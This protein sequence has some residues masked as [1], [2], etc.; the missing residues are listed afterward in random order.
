MIRWLILWCALVFSGATLATSEVS[1]EEAFPEKPPTA[2][3]KELM[4]QRALHALV[5]SELKVLKL[6]VSAYEANIARHQQEW[7]KSY[8]R[9]LREANLPPLVA[10]SGE[11]LQD[12]SLFHHL[13]VVK[14]APKRPSDETWILTLQGEADPL[15]LNQHFQRFSKTGPLGRKIFLSVSVV[16][17]N[18]SWED[19]NLTAPH[20]FTRPLER[21]WQ[22]WFADGKLPVSVDEIALCT[23]APCAE[24]LRA[25]RE[26]DEKSMPTFV[27]AELL[28]ADLLTVEI[29]LQRQVADGRLS[30]TKIDF[31][32]GFV[33]TEMN[34]K[35][36]L[37][38]SDL[39]PEQFTLKGSINKDF[40]STLATLCY[41]APLGKFMTLKNLAPQSDM[42]RQSM[43]VRL[44]N[45][46]HMGQPLRLLEWMKAR[47]RNI[48]LEGKL[49]SFNRKEA[50]ILIHF[51]GGGNN[52][53]SLVSNVKEL[54]SEWGKPLT[55]TDHAEGL[56]FGLPGALT[57]P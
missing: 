16:P 40:N 37:F 47:G 6:D 21:E 5:V 4:H 49:D 52:F 7:Q 51:V 14:F 26:H 12:E 54:E 17:V 57:S 55:V 15:L 18:F 36:R 3:D 42:P 22:K 27:S 50:R 23:S 9:R 38:W 19:L 8:E 41:R 46:M 10:T 11:F 32:G 1:V 34:S 44:E 13:S 33:L 48:Q 28:N 31:T 35:R 45:P 25:W 30:D 53:K 20:E 56:V 29:R 2:K 39:S 43:V 24:A